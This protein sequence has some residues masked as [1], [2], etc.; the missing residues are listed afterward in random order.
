MHLTVVIRVFYE[1]K[2]KDQITLSNFEFKKFCYLGGFENICGTRGTIS[3]FTPILWGRKSPENLL[4][5]CVL[6]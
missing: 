5:E 6:I 4:Q 1:G 3:T 2:M